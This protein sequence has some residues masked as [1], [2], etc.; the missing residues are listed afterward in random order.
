MAKVADKLPEV[1]S[2][3][4]L[5]VN[6]FNRNIT[7]EFLREST[8]LSPKT[9]K[10]YT[11]ALR[12]FFFWIKE[13]V[14]N[15]SILEI[16]SLDYLK[17][18]NSLIR[19]EVSPSGVRFKRSAISS[20]N[21]YILLYYE[22]KYPTFKNFISKKIANPPK[23]FVH[24]KEPLTLE[25]YK[26]LI[27]KLESNPKKKNY[28]QQLAYL[29]FSFATG[30]RREEARLLLK[31]VVNYKLI[32]KEIEI[33]NK[34]GVKEK[35]T[36]KYYLTHEIRCKGKGSVGKIRKIKFDENAMEAIKKW[37]EFRGEDDCPYVFVSKRNGQI[38]QVG[39]NTFNGWCKKI[40]EPIVGRRFHPHA[41]RESRAT[42]M[43][44]EEEMDIRVAQKLLGHE[45]SITTEI[46]IIRN[47]ED[48]SDEAFI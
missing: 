37:L 6:E 29:K 45:S 41:L 30:C 14:D 7:E 17:F 46:Y 3:Q 27:E 15:K 35:K 9:I 48:E 5:G 13:N 10:Q 21:G 18:Q 38:K 22:K 31:E 44:V 36:G 2:E 40:F 28:L 19:R 34:Q 24:A 26:V 16:E 12:Q 20:L 25:E 42:T 33:S 43:V 39:E 1:T 8:Q 11:S 47:K 23:A 4:W 32:E